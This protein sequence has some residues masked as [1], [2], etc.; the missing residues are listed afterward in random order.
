M[1]SIVSKNNI[2]ISIIKEFAQK[3]YWECLKSILGVVHK[4]G[5][6]SAYKCYWECTKKL[7]GVHKKVGGNPIINNIINYNSK[8]GLSIK[9]IS[10]HLSSA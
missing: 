5:G 7:V 8:L 9:I 6:G 2:L 4:K 1:Y 10:I 3:Q